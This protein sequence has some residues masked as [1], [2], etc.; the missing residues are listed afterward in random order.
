MANPQRPEKPGKNWTFNELD[1]YNIRINTVDTEAFFGIPNLPAPV[2]DPIIL[3]HVK[4]PL[5][6]QLPCNLDVFFS[7]L[8]LPSP[9]D[10]EWVD[11]FS[12]HLLGQ[13]LRFN[14]AHRVMHQRPNLSFLMN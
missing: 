5:D 1:S 10:E 8:R 2:V 11:D 3:N 14:T 7:Y 12:L 6:A 13:I 9:N 4:A